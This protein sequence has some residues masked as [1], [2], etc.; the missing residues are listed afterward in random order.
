MSD[1]GKKDC[2]IHFRNSFSKH[3]ILS[4]ANWKK[5]NSPT[6]SV[7]NL[8]RFTVFTNVW[9]FKSSSTVSSENRYPV[10]PREFHKTRICQ[11]LDVKMLTYT[12]FLLAWPDLLGPT[13]PLYQFM[14][15]LPNV[16]NTHSKYINPAPPLSTCRLTQP[17]LNGWIWLK[18]WGS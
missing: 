10:I 4:T 16:Q 12:I 11:L 2:P 9:I 18:Q 1:G 17:G 7:V 14:L 8:S 6:F 3:G 5:A 13:K 15:L